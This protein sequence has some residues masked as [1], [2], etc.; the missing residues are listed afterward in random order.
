MDAGRL[1]A[2]RG[3]GSDRAPGGR[4][5]APGCRVRGR[6]RLLLKTVLVCLTLAA[7]AVAAGA[8]TKGPRFLG[9]PADR[10]K[11]ATIGVGAKGG[12]QR[13]RWRDWGRR[14]ATAR[15]VYDIAGFAG[16]PGTGYRS[17]IFIRVSGR[18]KCAGGDRIYTRVRYRVRKPLAG[19]R[20]FRE[21]FSTCPSSGL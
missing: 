11:P 20:L 6:V 9:G 15:G 5:P 1:P 8:A 13:L 17:R 16:E 12:W 7:T 4:W 21:R 3:Y 10:G 14:S 2:A 19:R 18:K